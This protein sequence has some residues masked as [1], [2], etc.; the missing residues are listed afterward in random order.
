MDWSIPY[1]FLS[2][3]MRDIYC[4]LYLNIL[5][6]DLKGFQAHIKKYNIGLDTVFN[7]ES[8][9]TLASKLKAGNIFRYIHSN[10]KS[11][12]IIGKIFDTPLYTIEAFTFAYHLN[13]KDIFRR[14]AMTDKETFSK[15]QDRLLWGMLKI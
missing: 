3:E 10:K 6:D 2:D 9:L 1:T 8:L 13:D 14:M 4:V 5:N 7:G 15:F 12:N 11:D